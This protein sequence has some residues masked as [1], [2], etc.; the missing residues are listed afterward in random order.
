MPVRQTSGGSLLLVLAAV[1]SVPFGGA[2]A[3]PLVPK[4]S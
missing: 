4:A 1:V 3:A 2:V